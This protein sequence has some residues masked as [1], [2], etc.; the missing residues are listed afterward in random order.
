MTIRDLITQIDVNDDRAKNYSHFVPLFIEEAKT[1][2]NWSDWDS[3]VFEEYF[4]KTRDHCVSSAQQ[5]YFTLDDRAKLKEHWSEIAPF[6]KKLAEN[7]E[8]PD[9]ECYKT[10]K[11]IIRKYTKQDRRAATSRLIASLQPQ[12]L[13]TIIEEKNLKQLYNLIKKHSLGEL[14]KYEGGNWFKNSYN[15]AKFF[16]EQFPDKNFMDV[17]TYPWCVKDFLLKNTIKQIFMNKQIE[18]LVS[19]LKQKYQI[20]LQG[21]PG[22]GKTFTAKD[23]AEQIIFGNVSNSK[24]EQKGKLEKSDRFKLVQFHPSYTYEDFVRGIVV[25]TK[26]NQPE[27]IVKNKIIAD[28]AKRAKESNENYVLIIDEINRANLPAVLGE[29]IYALEYRGEIVESV[30]AIDGDRSLVLPPNLYIIGTM[31]TA[32]RSVGQIDYAI[33]R[34]FAFVDMLPRSLDIE[35]FDSELFEKVSKLFVKNF[36]EYKKNP[37]IRLERSEYLS[38]EFRPED[39]WIGHSY[40]IMN[41]NNNRQ[42]RLE[43]EIKPILKEY[44]KDGLLKSNAEDIINGL[45]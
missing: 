19:L 2:N 43:Y 41:G 30:Y 16:Q 40:F 21:A 8:V 36:D 11:S 39:V 35:G 12:L 20:I 42:M 37:E 6:L 33:R 14:P 9:W 18:D 4:N 44:L 24:S 26:N 34:R 5:G 15:I 31:N 27:Y 32:D 28:F 7:Q 10:L 23:I 22:T 1:G 17:A 3:G 29:L 13:C 38:E 45:L 25:E